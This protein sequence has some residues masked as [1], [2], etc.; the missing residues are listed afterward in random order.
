MSFTW[1]CTVA[2]T[3]TKYSTVTLNVGEMKSKI[4]YIVKDFVTIM[5]THHN[6]L[7]RNLA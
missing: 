6:L 7:K 2:L 4:Q 5:L 1:M 3:E